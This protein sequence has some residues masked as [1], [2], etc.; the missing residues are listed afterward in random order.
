MCPSVIYCRLQTH[1]EL[2]CC[3][4][5]CS[6]WKQAHRGQEVSSLSRL[7]YGSLLN[8]PHWRRHIWQVPRAP[9]HLLLIS[10]LY[11]GRLPMASSSLYP[12]TCRSLLF[13]GCVLFSL[14]SKVSA[15]KER[16][17]KAFSLLERHPWG[18]LTWDL[19]RGIIA[20]HIFLLFPHS[21][22]GNSQDTL[23]NFLAGERV[24]L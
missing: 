1:F 14:P 16:V 13:H 2:K 12:P 11:I 7:L 17:I 22:E 3:F 15:A 8:L 23:L 18:T 6:G 24:L 10:D 19:Y 4:L 21:L 20:H 5:I 9:L